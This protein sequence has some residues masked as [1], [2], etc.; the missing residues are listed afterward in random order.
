MGACLF[1]LRS[2]PLI[3]RW[4]VPPQVNSVAVP[5]LSFDAVSHHADLDF[6]QTNLVYEHPT[7]HQET[8]SYP[9]EVILT[10][11]CHSFRVVFHD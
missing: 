6:V 1:N 11:G 7:V 5:F 9:E 3:A 2:E 8:E 4:P 10:I